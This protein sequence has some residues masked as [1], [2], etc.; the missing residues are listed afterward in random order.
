[1]TATAEAEEIQRI[2]LPLDDLV[3]EPNLNLR[4]QLDEETVQRY[5]ESWDR[6]PPVTVFQDDDRWL[7][8]DGFHR[9]G[10][11]V[12]LGK[13]TIPSEVRPGGYREAMDYAAC[14]NM[15]HGLALTRAERRRAVEIKLR[16]HPDWSD[17]RIADAMA[18]SP[19]T[20]ARVRKS[21]LESHQIPEGDTRIGADGKAYPAGLARDPE[22]EGPR[23]VPDQ[24][25]RPPHDENDRHGE[26]NPTR[27]KARAQR[28]DDE[29]EH[30]GPDDD[31]S[32]TSADH[33]ARALADPPEPVA[34]TIDELLQ[35][36]ARQVSE[37]LQWSR[38]EGFDEAY[39]TASASARRAFQK[40]VAALA[41]R[42]DELGPD[43]I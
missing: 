3:L 39:A 36:M 34:P 15:R 26:G 38:G 21:L 4:D 9:H 23:S 41:Q 25:D 2:D 40:S 33:K 19:Q 7:L 1:M 16:L 17:R 13:R 20:V 28:L 12:R 31:G 6:L 37:V 24:D 11:A 18:V 5:A 35:L 8:A 10:A 14:A 30:D 42:A 22:L 43:A 29:T 32:G 27:S